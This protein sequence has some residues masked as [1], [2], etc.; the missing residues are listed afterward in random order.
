MLWPIAERY[1]V[2]VE[3]ERGVLD[4][5]VNR[6]QA[7]GAVRGNWQPGAEPG[8]A[9]SLADLAVAD[10][11]AVLAWVSGHGFLGLDRDDRRG[12]TIE[13]IRDAAG[14]LAAALRL[15]H[16]LRRGAATDEL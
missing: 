4:R 15:L 11:A 5:K 3:T 6:I 2:E 14:H 1:T 13:D 16:A 8:L 7:V 12:E 9:D 10:D